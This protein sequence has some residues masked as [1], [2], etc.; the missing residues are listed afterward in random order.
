M[1][2]NTKQTVL[3]GFAFL[4]ISA[5][6]QMYDNLVP[7]I[8]TRTLTINETVSGVILAADNALSLFL[9]PIFGSISDKYSSRLGRRRPFILRHHGSRYSYDGASHP[10]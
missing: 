2:L 5:F 8:L 7:L 3:I 1:K 10:R 6:W 4:A 9:L